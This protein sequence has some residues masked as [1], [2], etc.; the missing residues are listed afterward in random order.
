MNVKI[1][2]LLSVVGRV[3]QA[4]CLSSLQPSHQTHVFE[5]VCW[6]KRLFEKW[7]VWLC[8]KITMKTR[9]PNFLIRS[10]FDVFRQTMCSVLDR[11]PTLLRITYMQ[12]ASFKSL[13][14]HQTGGRNL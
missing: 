8:E 5:R 10:S 13:E 7:P 1:V 11:L 14:V 6:T 2:E 12:D 3:L 4:S 9:Q